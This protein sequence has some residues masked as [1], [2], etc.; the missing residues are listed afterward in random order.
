MIDHK[1]NFIYS[2]YTVIIKGVIDYRESI[3]FNKILS[4]RGKGCIGHRPLVE[5]WCSPGIYKKD[6]C[7]M[8]N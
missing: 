7:D 1:C 3:Q 5:S 6:I 8:N 4:N 2:V